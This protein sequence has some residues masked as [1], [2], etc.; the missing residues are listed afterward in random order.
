MCPCETR[1][2]VIRFRSTLR[3]MAP[4][5]PGH[6][7]PDELRPIESDTDECNDPDRDRGVTPVK[8]KRGED[9]DNLRRREE[10]HRRRSGDPS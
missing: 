6:S 5:K 2:A 10:W 8:E 9:R 1:L 7:N 3:G 4:D